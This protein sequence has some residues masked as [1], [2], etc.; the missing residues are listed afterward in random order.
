[1]PRIALSAL[2]AVVLPALMAC[3]LLVGPS[4]RGAIDTNLA[5]AT[6]RLPQS[7]SG[8][9]TA[10]TSAQFS[11]FVWV[12]PVAKLEQPAS[13]FTLPGVFSL[14]V[15]PNGAVSAALTR[16]SGSPTSISAVTGAGGVPQNEWSLLACSYSSGT[17]TVHARSVSGGALSASS[18][19]SAGFL[20]G[21]ASGPIT[22][23]ATD[24]TFGLVGAY[25]IVAIRSHAITSADATA[26]FEARVHHGPF[27]RITTSS[28]GLMNGPGGCVFMVNHS[29]STLP[30]NALQT[31]STTGERVSQV[32]I[33]VT[34]KNYQVYDTGSGIFGTTINVVRPVTQTNGFTFRSP[35]DAPLSGFFER[36]I[37]QVDPPLPPFTQVSAVAPRA[38]RLFTGPA[39]AGPVKVMISANSRA[40][41]G[42][43]GTSLSPGNFAHGFIGIQPNLVSGVM[44]RRPDNYFNPWFGFT[45]TNNNAFVAGTFQFAGFTDFS[46]FWSNS[47]IGNGTGPGGGVILAPTTIYTMRARPEGL[48]IATAPLVSQA[49]VLK[50]PGA[51]HVEYT[52]NKHS[53]Q[54]FFGTDVAGTTTIPLD[55]TTYTHTINTGAGDQVIGGTRI[56]LAGDKTGQVIA[57]HACYVN[58]AI[59]VISAVD[60]NFT[61]AGKTTVF[62]EK[63]LG[64][65]PG[66]GA[67]LRFGPWSF[68][69]LS[70]TFPALDALDPL[71]WRGLRIA[72]GPTGAGVV[73]YG[74]SAWRPNVDGFVI[75]V[76]GWG[77]NGYQTQIDRSF[78][79]AIPAW[80][81]VL[82]PDVWLEMFAQQDSSAFSQG[83]YANIIQNALPHTDLVWL[84][85]WVHGEPLFIPAPSPWDNY[86]LLEAEGRNIPAVSLL[87]HPQ[88]G[89]VLE[90]LSDGLRADVGHFNQRG[91]E[92][93]A[94]LW[95]EA[96]GQVALPP[97]LP[98][99]TNE[100]GM[101]NFADLNA[102]LSTFGQSGQGLIGDV[103]YN[104]RVDFVD[105]NI[106][107]SNFGV[108]LP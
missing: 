8:A 53:S 3:G 59:S 86:I 12:R 1:M 103:D 31:S 74:L 44:N 34:P 104:N 97:P 19:P 80:M 75:G 30:L 77:G 20:A 28:G 98:G 40:V 42:N 35:F 5:T 27:S 49:Y 39:G 6:L 9:T 11:F 24:S 67:I 25:A 100:D 68:E 94:T 78:A 82:S 15:M 108:S 52:P 70:Y 4:T 93:L 38:R 55:T 81:Q 23:G 85:D 18:A 64:V 66:N 91:N 63:S 73:I 45:G 79:A 96:L 26:V 46:R 50:Y 48:M 87:Q 21:P 41:Q 17:L 32:N 54:G 58:G 84:G 57:G 71:T 51:S 2:R 106:L 72:A 101:V 69:T 95:T 90:Q 29:I 65:I 89:S 62:F 56:A 88:G 13:V 102:V 7:P 92:R 107:L 83:S 36:E 22:I 43:D 47:D 14:T 33:A 76:S 61:T 60:F 10:L 99:D 16:A 37:P 105:L